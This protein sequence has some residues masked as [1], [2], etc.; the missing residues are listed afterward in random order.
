MNYA[1]LL[2]F[3]HTKINGHSLKKSGNKSRGP[4]PEPGHYTAATSAFV[5]GILGYSTYIPQL[6][7]CLWPSVVSCVNFLFAQLDFYP[8]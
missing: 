6:C 4:R 7:S 3:F 8:L 5:S 1:S 2:S